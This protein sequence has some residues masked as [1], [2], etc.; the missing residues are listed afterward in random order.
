[1][2]KGIVV[3]IVLGAILAC[4]FVVFFVLMFTRSV[5]TEG[6][7]GVCDIGVVSI[8]GTDDLVV[9]DAKADV[10]SGVCLKAGNTVLHTLYK[11]DFSNGCHTVVGI[12]THSITVTRAGSGRTCQ[13]ISHIDLLVAPPECEDEPCTPPTHTPT[14]TPTPTTTPTP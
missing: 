5:G 13:G 8:T 11:T 3:Q 9:Y 12:G 14:D 2:W 1:M 10:V 6:G 4:L 7:H